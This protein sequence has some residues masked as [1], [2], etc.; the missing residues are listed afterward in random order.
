M[1]LI[2]RKYAYLQ[3]LLIL[4]LFALGVAVASSSGTDSSISVTATADAYVAAASPSS[5][6]GDGAKLRVDGD[7]TM[8]TYLRF[9]LPVSVAGITKATLS[10]HAASDLPSGVEVHSVSGPWDESTLVFTNSGNGEPQILF[11][12]LK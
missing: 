2:D 7:P 10:L 11:E 3:G 5:N 4:V 12:E 9:V 1:K 8:V 6:E